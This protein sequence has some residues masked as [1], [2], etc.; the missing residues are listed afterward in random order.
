MILEQA[1]HR[2]RPAEGWLPVLL[3]LAIVFT[4]IAAVLVVEWVPES[5]IVIWT[6]LLGL[7]LG[8]LLAKRPLGW[9]PAW[10]LIVAYGLVFTV[11]WLGRLSPPLGILFSGWDA[12]SA[13]FR[14]NLGL[15]VDRSAGWLTSVFS[16]GTSK[17]TIVF[18]AGLGFAAWL[19]A[20]YAGWS[21]F[22]QHRPLAGITVMGLALAVNGYFGQASLWPVGMFVALAALLAAA[23][24]FADLETEWTKRGT[25]YS[26][27]IRL[28]LLV[29]SGVI[30]M[31]LLAMTFALPEINLRALYRAVFDRPA[32]H[33]AED[34]LSR[35]FAGVR[36]PGGNQGSGAG[37]GGG[38]G[39]SL[40]RGFLLGDPP[41]LYETVVMTASVRGD[42]PAPTHWRGVSFDVY[43]GRGWAITPERQ[44]PVAEAELIAIPEFAWQSSV[45]QSIHWVLGDSVNR[46]TLGLPQRFDQAVTAY[47]RGVEDLSRVRGRGNDY[48]AVSR[49]STATAA[50]LRTASLAGVPPAVTARYTELPE[51]VPERVHELA[52][53]VAGDPGVAATPY[54]QAK[55]LE[56]FLRQ[57]PYSL[58]VALPPAG[59]DPVDYFLFDLQS[60]YCDYYASA[61]VVMAR[62]LGLPARLATGFLPQPADANGLQTIYMVNAHSWAEVYFAG[63]GWV[64]FEPTAAFPAGSDRASSVSSPDETGLDDFLANAPPPIPEQQAPLPSPFWALGLLALLPLGWWLWQRRRTRAARVRGVQWAFGRLLRSAEMLGQPTAP[65]QTPHEFEAGLKQRLQLLEEKRRVARVEAQALYPDIENVVALYVSGQYSGKESPAEPAVNSWRRIRGRLWLLGLLERLPGGKRDM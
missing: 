3:L 24:H 28:D 1:W 19:L 58:E 17:E 14:Q 46:Y 50:E 64:E 43:T 57:Y 5:N 4:L 13:H 25:D 41:E 39:G 54:D 7:I 2:F 18:A 45:E 15:F 16:G 63:Y 48:S 33:E 11:I 36:Q 34:A 37:P 26:S 27:E 60:G 62:S 55:A 42:V 32:V 20:A 49:F 22:R 29:A 56:R 59:S 61:M 53:E 30:G 31:L 8:G 21:T 6:A 12:S 65:S 47:W 9:L 52:R 44:E 23:I 35:A 40:P 10:S 38:V 51:T